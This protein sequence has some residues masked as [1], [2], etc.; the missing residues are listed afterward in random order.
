MGSLVRINYNP[1]ENQAMQNL[2]QVSV[3]LKLILALLLSPTILLSLTTSSAHANVIDLTLYRGE[4]IGQG[5]NFVPNPSRPGFGLLI[6]QKVKNELD[7]KQ[8]QYRQAGIVMSSHERYH[9][10]LGFVKAEK[11]RVIDLSK[12]ASSTKEFIKLLRTHVAG[13]GG[14]TSN[15]NV[16]SFTTQPAVAAGYSVSDIDEEMG[17]IPIQYTADELVEVDIDA[18]RGYRNPGFTPRRA[19]SEPDYIPDVN[20]PYR[21]ASIIEGARLYRAS[22]PSNTLI[23]GHAS[24]GRD[25][26]RTLDTGFLYPNRGYNLPSGTYIGE[27]EVLVAG[28]IEVENVTN[29]L[30]NSRFMNDAARGW[31]NN[32]PVYSLNHLRQLKVDMIGSEFL[33]TTSGLTDYGGT[34]LHSLYLALE[35]KRT[36]NFEHAAFF[37]ELSRRRYLACNPDG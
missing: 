1:K 17:Y 35:Y 5:A 36:G 7:A 28:G 12:N 22:A 6:T 16:I 8:R 30:F 9:S 21:L 23:V 13:H 11:Q 3:T 26:A 24:E 32:R 37:T 33:P 2:N 34:L 4:N 10:A 20:R 29:E 14:S 31:A 27:G 25:T 15:V 19:V 18:L